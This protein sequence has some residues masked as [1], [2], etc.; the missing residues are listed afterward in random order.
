MR[1]AGEDQKISFTCRPSCPAVALA[2]AEASA[3]EDLCAIATKSEGVSNGGDGLW[4]D[5]NLLART[6]LQLGVSQPATTDPRG[7]AGE[8]RGCDPHDPATGGEREKID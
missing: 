7:E 3:K 4:A 2:Q 6:L 1:D 8:L 5:P